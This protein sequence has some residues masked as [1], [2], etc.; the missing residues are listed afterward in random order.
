MEKLEQYRHAIKDV[1]E[2]HADLMRNSPLP[3]EI[4]SVIAD[5]EHDEYL[6]MNYGYPQGKRAHH[7]RAHLRI[8][9]GKIWVE[10]DMTHKSLAEDLHDEGIAYEDIMI[11]YHAWPFL[12]SEADDA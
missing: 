7:L 2:Y 11:S 5:P 1:L 12:A 6:L 9:E 10:Y 4:V 8:H 3:G